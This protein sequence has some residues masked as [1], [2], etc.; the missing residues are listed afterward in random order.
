VEHRCAVLSQFNFHIK[1]VHL[2]HHLNRIVLND[3]ETQLA[4]A[5]VFN[6]PLRLSGMI[7]GL[8]DHGTSE[9]IGDGSRVHLVGNNAQCLLCVPDRVSAGSD[10]DRRTACLDIETKH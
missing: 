4:Q 8:V 9:V 7:S 10:I 6:Q 5:F 1:L 3:V 2:T